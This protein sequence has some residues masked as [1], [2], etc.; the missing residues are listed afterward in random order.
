M[1]AEEFI[2]R[3]FVLVDEFLKNFGKLRKSGPCPRL[4]DS[5]V[6]TIEIVG[7]FF[8][9]GSDKEIFDYFKTHLHHF[10]PQLNCRTT[11]SRQCANL[12]KVKQLLQKHLVNM[13]EYGNDGK[14]GIFLC[15]GF[16]IPTCH[17]KRV[18]P[19]NP[20]RI[21]GSFG[22]CAA[23][24]EHYFGFKGHILTTQEGLITEVA[25]A[26]ANIDERDVLP[27]LVEGY[28]GV[29]IA[30]KG[31]IRPTLKEDLLNRGLNLQTPLR[32]N[33]KDNRPKKLINKMMN[34]RRNV[35]TVIN[36]LCSRFKIQQIRAKDTWHLISKISRKILSHTIAFMIAGSLEFDGILE[37]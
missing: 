22:F 15:D 10:F 35:E 30:D 28:S 33:M 16:P 26:K 12:C 14:D 31:L 25:I 9:C 3:V 13:L 19:N 2:I 27:Q 34:I 1:S 36:Q 29:L 21:E 32:K 24:D 8:K 20:L 6:I 18:R 37:G 11:F 17:R 7:E 4:S 5:E 23:K